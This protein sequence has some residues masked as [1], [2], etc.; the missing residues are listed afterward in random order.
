MMVSKSSSTV[1]Q[2]VAESTEGSQ[3]RQAAGPNK[4]QKILEKHQ[5]WLNALGTEGTRASL[6]QTKNPAAAVA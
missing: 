4:I 5:E 6:D 1:E 2:T 3:E